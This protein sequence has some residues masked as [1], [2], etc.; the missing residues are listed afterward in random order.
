M[1]LCDRNSALSEYFTVTVINVIVGC[2]NAGM[3]PCRN[4]AMNDGHESSK[5]RDAITEQGHRDDGT[6]RRYDAGCLVTS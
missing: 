2:R 4:A 6:L 5:A 1:F 3:S